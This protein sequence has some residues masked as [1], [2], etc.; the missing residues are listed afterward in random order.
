MNK[1]YFIF[2]LL[3][4]SLNIY[5][6]EKNNS[7]YI[8]TILND[9]IKGKIENKKIF[10]PQKIVLSKDNKTHKYKIKQL[11]EIKV[12]GERYVRQKSIR[13]TDT[14][15]IGLF[16]KPLIENGNIIAY[17][18][19][20]TTL[21]R[22]KNYSFVKNQL[23]YFADDYSGTLKFLKQKSDSSSLIKFIENYNTFKEENPKSKSFVEEKLHF[24][25]FFNPQFAINLM[26]IIPGHSYLG[27]ELGLSTNLTFSP[28]L[29]LLLARQEK[30]EKLELFPFSEVVVKYYFLNG[31]RLK[32]DKST[33]M[34]SGYNISATYM[35][36]F[37]WNISKA[38]RA[39]IGFKFVSFNKFFIDYNI[40]AIYLIDRREEVRFWGALGFGYSF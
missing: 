31:N 24:K 39:E 16:T 22:K 19:K 15:Y 9:T 38:A 10:S 14:N 25:R 29:S 21:L 4:I 11:K 5:G 3:I 13:K 7:D 35:H 34:Y 23:K 18:Y 27:A 28:R 8:I 20:K 6:Q 1:K 26:G 2:L 32:K 40:G 37:Q 17:Q 33:F 36:P 30:G 12:S